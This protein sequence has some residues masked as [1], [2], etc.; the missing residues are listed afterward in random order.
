MIILTSLYSIPVL[1]PGGTVA[2]GTPMLPH[3]IPLKGRFNG[4]K[5]LPRQSNAAKRIMMAVDG[6]HQPS[7][8]LPPEAPSLQSSQSSTDSSKIVMSQQNCLADLGML[9]DDYINALEDFKAKLT[10]ALTNKYDQDPYD[11]R[12]DV[13]YKQSNSQRKALVKLVADS[14]TLEQA[15]N[16]AA[17]HLIKSKEP[18]DA[19]YFIKALE[20]DENKEPQDYVK[21]LEELV[22]QGRNKQ[23]LLAKLIEE[24][25]NNG[26]M[27]K[28]KEVLHGLQEI[29]YSASD[30]TYY[31]EHTDLCEEAL[32][33]VLK[34]KAK[35]DVPWNESLPKQISDM[36]VNRYIDKVYSK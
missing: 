20:H 16:N 24:T 2:F 36:T 1:A 25:M 27:G 11:E 26:S 6:M 31:N 7:I 15:S 19:Y 32:T 10:L 28:V 21:T 14:L 23:E 29:L 22:V 12:H 18:L 34:L 13:Y 35:Y 3:L 17:D 5:T 9:C 33:G 8:E 4:H 30:K